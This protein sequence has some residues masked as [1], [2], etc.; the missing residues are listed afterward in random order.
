M[1]HINSKTTTWKKNYYSLSLML[2]PSGVGFNVNGKHMIDCTDDQW[3]AIVKKDK[4]A[5][6]MRYK[7]WPYLDQWME[8]FGKDR[9]MGE[10]AEDLMDAAHEMYRKINLSQSVDDGD[11]HVSL[12]DIDKTVDAIDSTSQTHKADD[13]VR[14]KSKKR[15]HSGAE[16][17]M[18]EALVA[19][20]RGT[21]DRLET[22][23]GR[24]GYD[25]DISKARKELYSQLSSITGLS[26]KAIFEVT[27][28]LAKEV[29][30]L[31]VF[32]SLPWEAK[33]DYIYYLLEIINK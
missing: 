11:Y 19:I 6:T 21:E 29:E 24:M 2:Q 31:D 13:A 32:S 12:E 3:D 20:T 14:A 1:P 25:F 28:L 22:I 23:A 26:Q 17:R 15:K 33:P 16:D 7:S 27:D 5:S 4:N 30:R 10:E 18:F 8:I 9:A